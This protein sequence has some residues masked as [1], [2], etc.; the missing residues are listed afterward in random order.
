MSLVYGAGLMIGA[1]LH[2]LT[3]LLI[4]LPV[5]LAGA[6]VLTLPQAPGVPGCSQLFLLEPLEEAQRE[7]VPAPT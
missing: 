6:I 4:G 7:E 2:T 5:A 3:L 1:F